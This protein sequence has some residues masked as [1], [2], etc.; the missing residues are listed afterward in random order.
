MRGFRIRNARG[1]SVVDHV[2]S[3]RMSFLRWAYCMDSRKTGE[4]SYV[5]GVVA[6]IRPN[7]RPNRRE[8]R[9]QRAAL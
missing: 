7:N 5:D 2:D 1:R 9:Y 6:L 4:P 3:H 8:R